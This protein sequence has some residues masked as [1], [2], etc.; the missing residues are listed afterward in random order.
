MFLQALN[1]AL[2]ILAFRAGPQDFPYSPQL[3]QAIVP[4]AVTANY[5]VFMQVLP[6]VMSLAMAAGAVGG[7]ALIMRG[8]LRARGLEARLNQSLNAMLLCSALLTA[9]LALPFAEVAPLIHKVA[10]NPELLNDPEA[11]RASPGATFAMN[12]LNI[13]N[14]AVS[15]FILRQATNAGLGLGLLFAILTALAVAFLVVVCGSFA[16]ALFGAASQ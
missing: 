11:L 7:L 16:G 9:L 3:S 12:L 10:Q 4:L 1:A 2:R 13:W 5:L 6:A 8:L 15:V 14:F